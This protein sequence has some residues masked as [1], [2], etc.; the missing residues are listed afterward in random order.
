MGSSS[1]TENATNNYESNET[2]TRTSE[3]GFQDSGGVMALAGDGNRTNIEILDAGAIGNSFDFAKESQAM[4]GENFESTLGL[5][6]ITNDRS[7]DFAEDNNSRAYDFAARSMDAVEQT[8]DR[9]L[10]SQGVL[11]NAFANANNSE[12]TLG[13]SNLMMPALFLGAAFVLIKTLKG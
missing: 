3:S 6:E 10:K 2:N 13:A 4:L 1:S 11:S 8:N 7:Y 9:A 5:A 12:K